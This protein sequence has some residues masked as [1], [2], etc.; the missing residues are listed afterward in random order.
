MCI[1]D[2]VRVVAEPPTGEH[3]RH[4]LANSGRTVGTPGARGRWPGAQWNPTVTWITGVSTYRRVMT[5]HD[6]AMARPVNEVST[7]DICLLYTSDA[8]DER[9]SVDLGGR[10]NFKKKKQNM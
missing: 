5:G 8:A 6:G 4:D 10:G 3:S 2:R 9:S 7:G 1:R